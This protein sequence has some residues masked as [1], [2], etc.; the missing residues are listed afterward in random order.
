MTETLSKDQLAVLC[1]A[2]MAAARQAAVLIQQ[3]DR[4]QLEQVFKNAGSS[5]ASQIV[6]EVDIR[7]EELIRLHLQDLSSKLNIAFVGEE[8]IYKSPNLA[9]QRFELP[10]FWCV[11]PL[12]GT[13]AYA[14]GQSGYAVSIALVD[15]SGHSLI[16]VV[17]D[18]VE[19]FLY[20]SMTGY[21]SFIDSDTASLPWFQQDLAPESLTFFSDGSFQNHS[22][23][24]AVMELLEEVAVAEGLSG[25][26]MVYGGGAVMNAVQAIKN[27]NAV[28]L[29]LP[30]KEE[31]GGSIWDFAATA[32]L[33]TESGAWVS[34]AFGAP[35]SL[36]RE[37]PL[38]MNKEG[39]L[40]ASNKSLAHRI[41]SA[42]STL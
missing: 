28:Y 9:K 36:N 27:R 6:T 35:L 8:S 12:D 38:F 31:G 22:S 13:L 18:P 10:Y 37:G 14:K 3:F 15:R 1:K 32:C 33:A 19:Q 29:K 20:H 41:M 42:L 2:A 7:S 11:D 25:V 4:E 26:R 30:K 34:D 24:A 16:G 5:A 21:G 40:F 23:Y 17:Y 39:I